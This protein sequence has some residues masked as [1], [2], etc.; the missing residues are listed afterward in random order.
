MLIAIVFPQ[1]SPYFRNFIIPALALVMT[2]SLCQLELRNLEFRRSF[3]NFILNY[4]FLSGLI[5]LLSSNLQDDSMR[6][7]FIVMAA[8]PPAIA[9]VPFSR[10]LGGDVMESM[11]SSGV[12]YIL[13][14]VL[15]P[16]IVLIFTG[17][18][19]GVYDI[20]KALFILILLPIFASRA[21]RVENPTP[22]INLGFG[23]VIYT[24]IGLNSELI[25]GNLLVLLDIISIAFA[26]TF[27]SGSLA[28]LIFFLIL[29]NSYQQAINR[30]LFSSYKNL[31]FTAGVA[32]ALFG[33]RAAV[34]AAICVLFEI[35]VF[36]YYLL[37]K[38]YL[39]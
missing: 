14:L 6:L 10:L 22:V 16:T 11:V 39:K 32:I 25:C 19:V 5:L 2:L 8:A 13:S 28:F 7:G 27:L 21:I 23:F 31:G 33:D 3:W 38:R 4:L 1:A 20:L 26:R 18:N 35:L 30:A 34:P 29:K 15:T 36:N 24:I 12:I 9:V 17:K 37:L